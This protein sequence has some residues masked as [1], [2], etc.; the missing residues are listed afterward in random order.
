MVRDTSQFIGDV[1]G[2]ALLG[3]T[4]MLMDLLVLTRYYWDTEVYRCSVQGG[5]PKHPFSIGCLGVVGQTLCNYDLEAAH[6]S[7]AILQYYIS[8]LQ[9]YIWS[10]RSSIRWLLLYNVSFGQGHLKLQNFR[11][12]QIPCIDILCISFLRATV[13]SFEWVRQFVRPLLDDRI[14]DVNPKSQSNQCTLH[15]GHLV[16]VGSGIWARNNFEVYVGISSALCMI[17]LSLSYGT[18]EDAATQTLPTETFAK[19]GIATCGHRFGP[20]TNSVRGLISWYFMILQ[21]YLETDR[22]RICS[23]RSL[24]SDS[25]GHGPWASSDNWLSGSSSFCIFTD[26]VQFWFGFTLVPCNTFPF[27]IIFMSPIFTTPLECHYW[28]LS[29]CSSIACLTWEATTVC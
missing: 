18:G 4:M 9:S 1:T 5:V 3:L 2:L 21:N 13:W 24:L 8:V 29:F 22:S 28:C 17:R 10:S 11:F 25:L 6:Y 14:P 26:A 16:P 12:W 27:T 15:T 20:I 7:F 19:L 23:L